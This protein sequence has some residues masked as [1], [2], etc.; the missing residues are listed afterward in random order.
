MS[1]YQH[2]YSWLSLA[3]PPYRPLFSADPQGYILYRHRAAVCR[4]ELDVLLLLVHVKESTGVHHMSSSL[5]LQLCPACLVRRILIVFVMSSR[6]PYSC[7]FVGCCLQEL[8]NIARNIL[9]QLPSSFFSIRLVSVYVA[10]LYGSIDMIAAWKKLR[11]IL[12]VRSDFH[13]TESLSIAVHI[14]I[15]IY[16]YI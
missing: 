16:I 10:H 7:C 8:F 6:W 9:V 14:Y 4:F 13:M 12:S 11:F 5:L 15:Y 3:T 1:R 2:G